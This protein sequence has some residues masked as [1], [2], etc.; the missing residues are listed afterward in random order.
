M[1]PVKWRLMS[2]IGS[3]WDMP[4]PAAPPLMPNT[5]PSEGSRTQMMLFL[6]SRAS[7]WPR[8]TVVRVLPSPSGVGVMA[9]T[10]MSFPSGSSL[11]RSS[12]SR[13]TFALCAP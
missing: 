5:G 1:S 12:A 6:P 13:P 10:R 7:D 11:R 8:P 2:S 3:T 4:P 9:V